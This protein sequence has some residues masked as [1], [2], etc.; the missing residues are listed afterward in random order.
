MFDYVTGVRRKVYPSVPR[1]K[2][3]C[4]ENS[5]SSGLILGI[6]SLSWPFHITHV[7]HQR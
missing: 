2:D 4:R 1:L 6:F 7:Q 3:Y 5:F